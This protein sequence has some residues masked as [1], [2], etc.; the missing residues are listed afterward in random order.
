MDKE[1]K[2]TIVI[3]ILALIMI[4]ISIYALPMLEVI[5]ERLLQ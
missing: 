3:G 5:V 1:L 4:P 2:R